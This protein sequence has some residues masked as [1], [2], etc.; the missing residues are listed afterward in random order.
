MPDIAWIETVPTSEA[1]GRLEQ[2]Y[3]RI[4][5]PGG[6]VDNIMAAHSLRPHTMEGH[7]A[8]YKSVLHHARNRLPRWLLETIGVH[9]SL[10]NRCEYCVE[11]HYAGLR[12]LLGDDDRATTIRTALENGAP[13][14]VLAPGEAAAVRYAGVLTRDPAGVEAS[15][16]DAMRAAGLSDGEILEV[17]QVAAYFAYAN[18][19]VLGLGV[20]AA[21]DVLGL[22]PSATDD[23]NDW[24]HR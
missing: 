14:S 5:G 2:L 22:S 6:A 8:L 7:L 15:H 9:V 4:G 1:T 23:P 11:H 3:R 21:G 12:R 20:T 19:T 13:E 16:V 17:N 24:S 18:R 10:L